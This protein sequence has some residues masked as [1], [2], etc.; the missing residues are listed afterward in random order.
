MDG[1]ASLSTEADARSAT[2]PTYRNQAAQRVLTVLSAF[3]VA[4]DSHGVTALARDLGMSK[5]MVHRALSTLV[6]EG[7]LARDS[8]GDRYQLGYAVL[9]LGGDEPVLELGSLARPY[10]ERL[11]AYT[12]ESVYLSVI[13]GDNRVTIDEI[14]P[15][16]PRVLRSSR[17][18]PVP[19][20][21]TKMSRTLLAHMADGDIDEYLA[22][23]APLPRILPFRDAE[24]ET[25]QGVWDDVKRIRANSA[26]VWRNPVLTSA[27]YAI[28]PLLDHSSRPHAIVTVGGPRERFDLDRINTTL[29]RMTEILAPLSQHLRFFPAMAGLEE[30]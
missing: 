3:A 1:G 12:G 7:W 29:P 2:R 4:E 14:L 17:G 24:S 25:A 26:V 5:N 6:K 13:M 22:R 30:I 28:F 9:G 11:H 10:L 8:T 19:L 15:P 27:A 16:G 23:A 18:T 20:H 21:C